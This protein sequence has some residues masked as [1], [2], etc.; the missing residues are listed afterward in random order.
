MKSISTSQSLNNSLLRSIRA[1]K[2]ALTFSAKDFRHLGSSVAIRKALER[3]VKRGDL[4]RVRRGAYYRPHSHPLLGKTAPD[5]MDLVR[6]MMNDSGAE[7]QVSGAYAANLLHLSDQVPAKIVILTDGV[8]RKIPLGK[9]MLD[10]RR[11]APR[12]LLGAGK[13]AGLVI[14][15]IRY[16]RPTGITPDVIA[17]LRQRLDLST[18]KDLVSLLP[19]LPAWMQPV[20]EQIVAS[21]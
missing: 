3:M 21:S 2:G 10:F 14:Q 20:V 19:K 6:G 9:L 11:A 12:H 17:G 1:S 4:S 7:W 5:P 16:L 18:K 15:A 13:P 8:S